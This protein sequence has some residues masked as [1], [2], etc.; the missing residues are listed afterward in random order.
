MQQGSTLVTD[1]SQAGTGGIKHGVDLTGDQLSLQHPVNTINIMLLP[2]LLLSANIFS[3]SSASP[4]TAQEEDVSSM[5][6]EHRLEEEEE[7]HLI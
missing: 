6:A 2:L 5:A 3:L 4:L 1:A 7:N